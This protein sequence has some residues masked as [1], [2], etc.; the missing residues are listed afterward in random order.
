VRLKTKLVLAI[1]LMV[2]LLVSTLSSIYVSQIVSQRIQDDYTHFDF[3]AKEIRQATENALEVDTSNA[4][5][6]AEARQQ[7]IDTLQGDPGLNSQLTSAIGYSDIIF[8]AAVV[9]SESRVLVSTGGN[10]TGEV[11]PPRENFADLTTIGFLRQLQWVYGKPKLYEIRAP[12]QREGQPFGTVRVGVVTTFLKAQI[13]PQLNQA[14]AFS[15]ISI[16]VSLLLAAGLSNFALRPLEVIARRLDVMTAQ[17]ASAPV[18]KS[19]EPR[20]D[21]VRVVTSKIDRLGRE[22]RDVKEVFSALK[23]NLDQIMA[24]LQDGLVLFTRDWRAVLVS[25]SAET[26]LGKPRGDVLGSA[27]D[28]IFAE[29]TPLGRVVLDAIQAHQ[30]IAGG[31]VE[32]ENHRRVQVSLDFI[33]EGGERIGA[34]LT[35]RDAESVRRIESEIEL[36][37]RLAAIGRLTSG[38]AHEVRNPINAIVVHLEILRQKLQQ[39]DPD[40]QRHMSVIGSEIQRLDRVVQMLVDFTRPVEL[41]L[42]DVDLRRVVEDVVMLSAPDAE[43]HS[44]EL[45][46]Q[47]PPEPLMVKVDADLVKQAVLNVVLNGVQAMPDG[48]RLTICARRDERGVQLDIGDAGQGIPPE[49]RDKIF[50]L[51]FTTKK[52]GSGIGLAMTFRVMQLHNGSVEFDT[53]TQGTTFHLRFPAPEAAP[54]DALLEMA[55]HNE[56]GA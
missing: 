15:V 53:S 30:P 6:A 41:R 24:N 46:R 42:V 3:V 54:R 12:I 52:S 47:L 9:D 40:V 49:I 48:G 20:G 19:R 4:R 11:L 26:F 44:V 50:D 35:M 29:S 39:A 22:I 10:A 43:R 38:V 36:S 34:L 55:A 33:E 13:K 32:T 5:N 31:E 21:E 56:A 1:S 7:I 25:A 17:I 16:F 23:E 18:A 27:A 28:A 8:D 45:V 51:Y 37:R 2:M 14:L